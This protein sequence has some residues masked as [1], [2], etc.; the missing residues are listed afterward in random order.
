M[1]TLQSNFSSL[2]VLVPLLCDKNNAFTI[3]Y[4]AVSACDRLTGSCHFVVQLRWYG[5]GCN[6][7]PDD[8]EKVSS[9]SYCFL[10]P[11]YFGL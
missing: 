6:F 3:F 7:C 1:M 4:G 5:S 11:G 8:G 10:S 9:H 2:L